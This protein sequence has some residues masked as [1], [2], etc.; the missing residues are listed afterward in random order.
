MRERMIKVH[1]DR[2]ASGIP[3]LKNKRGKSDTEMKPW[4]LLGISR[5]TYYKRRRRREKA[6]EVTNP[7][8]PEFNAPGIV[9]TSTMVYVSSMVEQLNVKL[10]AQLVNAIVDLAVAI[11]AAKANS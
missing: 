10:T 6:K 1:A 8:T 5:S 3:W 2:K 9:P 11:T 4:E 7:A